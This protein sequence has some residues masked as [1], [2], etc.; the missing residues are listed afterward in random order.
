MSITIHID[1]EMLEQIEQMSAC[2]YTYEEMS[3]YLQLPK[4]LFIEEA[5]LKDSDIWTAIQRGRLASEFNIFSKL[6]GNAASGNIT[7]AQQFIKMRDDKE[8][9]NIKARIFYGEN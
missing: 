6:Q 7:A 3:I 2:A 8:S 5:K 1:A 9:E 4:K